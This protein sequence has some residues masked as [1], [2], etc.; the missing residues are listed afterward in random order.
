MLRRDLACVLGILC[1]LVVLVAAYPLRTI[2]WVPAVAVVALGLVFGADTGERLPFLIAAACALFVLGGSALFVF[3]MFSFT[4]PR[5]W[6]GMLENTINDRSMVSIWFGQ[7]AVG[8]EGPKLFAFGIFGMVTALAFGSRR[9]R[10]LRRRPF[11]VRRGG[12]HPWIHRADRARLARADV[13]LFRIS[14][15]AVL[16]G[17]WGLG[18]GL[19][20]VATHRRGRMDCRKNR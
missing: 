17:F 2:L 11:T 1:L 19:L 16:Y 7:P 18:R 4:T 20:D 3:G 12:L 10:S 5:F 6:S 15:L 9:L 8:P 14:N 13:P